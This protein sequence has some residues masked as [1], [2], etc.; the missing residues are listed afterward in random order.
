MLD[1]L[2]WLVSLY[3]HWISI[4]ETD[5]ANQVNLAFSTSKVNILAK[6]TVTGGWKK[7]FPGEAVQMIHLSTVKGES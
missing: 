6:F 2:H 3:G 7:V 5:V 1:H 4:R